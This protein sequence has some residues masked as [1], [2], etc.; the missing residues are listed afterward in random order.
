MTRAEVRA[1]FADGWEI[2]SIDE[3]AFETNFESG[4]SPAWLATITRR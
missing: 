2:D 3:V 4:E 1:A